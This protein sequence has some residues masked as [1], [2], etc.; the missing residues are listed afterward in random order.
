MTGQ[1]TISTCMRACVST[2]AEAAA[3]CARSCKPHTF[4]VSLFKPQAGGGLAG[5]GLA[6]CHLRT[7][8]GVHAR[9]NAPHF[10]L[11][12]RSSTGFAALHRCVVCQFFCL[13]SLRYEH[14]HLHH[15]PPIISFTAILHE[16]HH[17]YFPSLPPG[18]SPASRTSSSASLASSRPW[19]WRRLSVGWWITLQNAANKGGFFLFDWAM[20]DLSWLFDW[21]ADSRRRQR[22][23]HSFPASVRLTWRPHCV[24]ATMTVYEC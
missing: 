20:E 1:A 6:G 24:P 13:L 12:T 7:A 18:H 4:L 21:A 17:I 14:L 22:R 11:H 5:C 2:G 10:H 15:S 3:A 23:R 9:T 16:Y 8:Y 19:R